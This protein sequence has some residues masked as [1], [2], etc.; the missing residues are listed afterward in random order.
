MASRYG[1]QL[2]QG[3]W[4]GVYYVPADV[5]AKFPDGPQETADAPPPVA[6]ATQQPAAQQPATP[7]AAQL[8]TAQPAATALSAALAK[9]T[10]AGAPQSRARAFD[11]PTFGKANSDEGD[12][13]EDTDDL[14]ED[15]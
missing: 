15:D 8:I 5:I 11:A 6:S 9:L 2:V 3:R 14:E 1:S 12:T 7:A 10:T 4:T 13:S